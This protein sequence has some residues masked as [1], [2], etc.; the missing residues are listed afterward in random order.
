MSP[1]SLEALSGALAAKLGRSNTSGRK[2]RLGSR[3]RTRFH[4]RLFAQTRTRHGLASGLAVAVA[5]A[6]LPNSAAGQWTNRYPKVEGYSHHVYLEGYEL[7][8]L[9][10]GPM[11]PAPSPDGARIAFASRGWIWIMDLS[12]GLARRLTSGREIDARP[13]WSP[14]GELIAFVRDDSEDTE[15]VW[16]EVD[17]GAEAGRV[18]T[19]AIELDPAFSADG[20]KIFYSSGVAGTLDLWAVDLASG[21]RR[22]VTDSPGIE[23]KPQPAWRSLLYLSKGG[24]SDRVVVRTGEVPEPR[25]VLEGSIASMARPALS[26]DGA[27]VAVNWPAQNGWDLRLMSVSDPGPSI[28]LYS[29][30]LPLAPA[31]HPDGEWLYF[32]E[33]DDRERMH[34]KRV[35][36]AGGPS[37]AVAVTGWDWGEPTGRLRIKTALEGGG[38]PVPA[39]LEVLDGSGHPAVPGESPA[40]FDGQ[41]GRTYFYS[42]GVIEVTV[43][44][45]TATL[46][47]VQGLATPEV[48]VTVAVGAGG[49]AEAEIVLSPLWDAGAEGWTTGEHHFHLNYGGPYDLSPGDLAPMMRGEALDF[50]TP[51]LANLHNRFEDQDLWMWQKSDASPFI[52]F[53]Q[54]TRSHF[55]GHLGLIGI[56]ELF[57]PWVWG[58]GYEVYGEDDRPNADALRHARS[59]AGFAF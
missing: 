56:N 48:S 33:A 49:V 43:P 17:T 26:P 41:S 3:L 44:A 12:T 8:V 39:R 34:L 1:T 45:G 36:A 22:P 6:T 31:W 40:R 20:T 50:A 55:L 47:A 29:G 9:T 52:R 58:P 28:L 16:V 2:R 18:D 57:W 32:S 37:E 35:R 24:G 51:L 7:P 5:F 13:A 46:S 25:T 14:G 38:V 54:E 53:G 10:N 59:Q 11:D 23:V 4:A 19:P 21:E 27:V 15:I 42:P 30:G